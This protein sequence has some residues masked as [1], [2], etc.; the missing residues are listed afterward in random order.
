MQFYQQELKK[1]Y[2]E[3]CAGFKQVFEKLLQDD[4][5]K[6]GTSHTFQKFRKSANLFLKNYPSY[7][8]SGRYDDLLSDLDRIALDITSLKV[9]KEMQYIFTSMEKYGYWAVFEKYMKDYESMVKNKFIPKFEEYKKQLTPKE[10]EQQQTLMEW[11]KNLKNCSRYEC[12]YVYF[13]QF[14]KEVKP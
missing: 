13:M 6:R 7:T 10:L 3:Q 11:F 9:K 4:T 2:K 8:S 5:I 12:Y 14:P 1:V